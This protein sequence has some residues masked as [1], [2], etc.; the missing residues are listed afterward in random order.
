MYRQTRGYP[1][2]RPRVTRLQLPQKDSS[3][4]SRLGGLMEVPDS[5]VFCLEDHAAHEETHEPAA[6]PLGDPP[7]APDWWWTRSP[8]EVLNRSCLFTLARRVTSARPTDMS[9]CTSFGP[10]RGPPKV[11]DVDA[12]MVPSLRCG[13]VAS[14]WGHVACPTSVRAHPPIPSVSERGIYPIRGSPPARRVISDTLSGLT[15]A[16]HPSSVLTPDSINIHA[17]KR[18]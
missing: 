16:D 4:T 9:G 18:V 14:G 15:S 1:P 2:I 5:R 12:V 13:D 17:R 11:R 7:R 8:S 10:R 3:Q 6:P